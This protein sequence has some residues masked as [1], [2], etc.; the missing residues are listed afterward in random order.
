MLLEKNKMFEEPWM[1]ANNFGNHPLI[2]HDYLV[3][4]FLIH[5]KMQVWVSLEKGEPPKQKG[6]QCFTMLASPRTF[7]TAQTPTLSGTPNMFWANSP[8]PASAPLVLRP[9]A[10]R[11]Q[12]SEPRCADSWGGRP[13]RGCPPWQSRQAPGAVGDFVAEHGP[14][15]YTTFTKRWGKPGGVNP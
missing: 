8:P 11:H 15:K 2:R 9:A 1:W 3:T 7:A 14:N 6:N 10:S 12:L 4:A 5:I 13:K